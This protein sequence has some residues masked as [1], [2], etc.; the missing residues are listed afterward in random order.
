[1]DH[2]SLRSQKCSIQNV[3][4]VV[5]G[6]QTDSIFAEHVGFLLVSSTL[7]SQPC[8]PGVVSKIFGT[9]RHSKLNQSDSLTPSLVPG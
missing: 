1:M 4:H 7:L 3:L 9:F 2:P 5:L 6:L 8:D